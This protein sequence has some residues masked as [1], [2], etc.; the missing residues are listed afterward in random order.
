[1]IHSVPNLVEDNPEIAHT[2]FFSPISMLPIFDQAMWECQEEIFQEHEK[3]SKM[4]K[5]P[6]CHVRIHGFQFQNSDGIARYP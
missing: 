2:I 5:K 3:Q 1:M 4:I 6:N